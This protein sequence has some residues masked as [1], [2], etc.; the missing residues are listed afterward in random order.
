MRTV[1][2]YV[3]PIANF[4]T[5]TAAL[6]LVIKCSSLP[7]PPLVSGTFLGEYFLPFREVNSE[8][9]SLALSVIA[10]Y[11]FYL[12]NVYL[13]TRRNRTVALQAIKPHLSILVYRTFCLIWVYEHLSDKVPE[14]DV[15]LLYRCF[16]SDIKKRADYIFPLAGHLE[17]EAIVVVNNIVINK[18]KFAMSHQKLAEICQGLRRDIAA[19]VWAID[20]PSPYGEDDKW[21]LRDGKLTNFNPNSMLFKFFVA[22]MWTFKKVELQARLMEMGLDRVVT[23]P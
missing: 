7:L 8:L 1:A 18:E 19:L 16:L 23:A 2:K 6:L 5:F 4:A 21:L 14:K 20:L 13:P 22:E 9:S 12:I 10:A 17:M 11:L 15:H 3:V